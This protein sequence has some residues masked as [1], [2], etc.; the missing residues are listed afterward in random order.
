MKER[1]IFNILISTVK[2]L[3]REEI[4][5]KSEYKLDYMLY[6]EFQKQ[7]ITEETKKIYY[8]CHNNEFDKFKSLRNASLDKHIYFAQ[9]D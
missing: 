7:R 1:N 3:Q 9:D 4:S 2:R 8:Y 5:A 6:S